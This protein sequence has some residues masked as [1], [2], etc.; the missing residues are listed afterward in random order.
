MNACMEIA[1]KIMLNAYILINYIIVCLLY[2]IL[3]QYNELS[4]EKF[5]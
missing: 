5:D 2:L 3:Y 1:F 4:V